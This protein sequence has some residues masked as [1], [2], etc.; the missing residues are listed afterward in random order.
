MSQ[1]I[2]M[3]GLRKMAE[4]AGLKLSADELRRLLPGV[5]RSK[6]QAAELRELIAGA[7]EPVATFDLTS[8]AQN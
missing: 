8:E 5:N 3:D 6:K 4:R 7:D 1:E 2:S